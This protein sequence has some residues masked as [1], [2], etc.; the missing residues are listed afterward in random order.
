MS[1]DHNFYKGHRIGLAFEF[2]VGGG[3]VVGQVDERGNLSGPNISYI[4]PDLNT[5]I[6]GEFKNSQLISGLEAELK[7]VEF[8][9][10]GFLR[11][12]Y[13]V[14]GRQFMKYEISTTKSMGDGPLLPDPMEYK[15][16]I[17]S[18]STIKVL[19]NYQQ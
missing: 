14:K 9:L 18:N 8:T 5:M 10:N 7:D 6:V 4:Y 15:Y 1:S 13:E 16:C 11:P 12:L 2:K 19:N 17:V 3:F